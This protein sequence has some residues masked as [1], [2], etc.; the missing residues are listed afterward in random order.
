MLNDSPLTAEAISRVEQ[1]GV[2]VG[3]LSSER[4]SNGMIAVFEHNCYQC[5]RW[6]ETGDE[7]AAWYVGTLG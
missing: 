7:A 3:P 4:L 6:A 2:K 5:K 1:V